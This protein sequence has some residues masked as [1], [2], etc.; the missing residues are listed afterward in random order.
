MNRH[1]P[2]ASLVTT[3]ANHGWAYCVAGLVC[4][5]SILVAG[6]S[7]ASRRVTPSLEAPP[8]LSAEELAHQGETVERPLTPDPLRF[9][10]PPATLAVLTNEVAANMGWKEHCI[11]QE[12]RKGSYTVVM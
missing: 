10:L 4:G 12:E 1:G 6:C 3:H 5:M 9:G 2:R 8:R 7:S 11:L